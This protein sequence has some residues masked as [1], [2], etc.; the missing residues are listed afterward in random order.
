MPTRAAFDY[1]LVRVVPRVEREEFL[2]VGAVVFCPTRRFLAARIAL[3]RA[4][5]AALA[6]DPSFDLDLVAKHVNAIAAICDGD[7]AA[8]PMA[9]LPPS[10]RFHWLVSPRSTMVQTSPVHS[11]LTD[12]PAATLDHLMAT[13]VRRPR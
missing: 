13:M 7:P 8:G 5:L 2:N 10:E 4:R 6:G 12:D 9:T 11:G 3:D 1:A